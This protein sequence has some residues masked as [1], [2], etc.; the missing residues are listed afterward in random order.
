MLTQWKN[1]FL[2][3]FHI[4][5]GTRDICLSLVYFTYVIS[6]GSILVVENNNISC[7]L[8]MSYIP[9]CIHY[10]FFIYLPLMDLSLLALPSC[11][12]HCY[13]T[14]RSTDISLTGWISFSL[15]IYQE[16]EFLDHMVVLFLGFWGIS[17]LFPTIDILIYILTSYAQWLP[18]LHMLINTCL[19]SFW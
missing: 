6:C 12:E 15:Y 4:W 17:I 7:F 2:F 13:N 5:V 18:F 10:I 9:L 11:C 14:Y 16:V 8:W 1:L 3:R 19:L